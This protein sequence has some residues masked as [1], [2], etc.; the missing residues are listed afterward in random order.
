MQLLPLCKLSHVATNNTH[1]KVNSL[2]TCQWRNYWNRTFFVGAVSLRKNTVVNGTPCMLS[3]TDQM[4]STAIIIKNFGSLYR[5]SDPCTVLVFKKGGR[6]VTPSCACTHARARVVGVEQPLRV[7]KCSM[8]TVRPGRN[9][10]L[11]R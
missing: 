5:A 7:S 10:G 8:Y 11:Q 3:L 1:M 4:K 9:R 6:I 2:P